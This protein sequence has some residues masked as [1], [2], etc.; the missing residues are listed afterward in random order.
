MSSNIS[1]TITLLTNHLATFK[2]LIEQLKDCSDSVKDLGYDIKTCLKE[3]NLLH[4][5]TL[6]A[7]KRTYHSHIRQ[8]LSQEKNILEQMI[9]LA[10]TILGLKKRVYENLDTLLS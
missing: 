5:Y 9:S 10:F 3:D 8:N 7:L 6:N 2:T 1:L 4:A